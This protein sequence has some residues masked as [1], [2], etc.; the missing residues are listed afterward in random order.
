LFN[1]DKDYAAVYF[2]GYRNSF[3]KGTAAFS[4]FELLKI[5]N[6]IYCTSSVE[7]PVFI[8]CYEKSFFLEKIPFYK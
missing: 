6:N 1:Y 8:R 2:E 3:Y 5:T 7:K 4:T